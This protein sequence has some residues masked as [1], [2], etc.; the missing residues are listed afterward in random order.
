MIESDLPAAEARHHHVCKTNFLYN[1]N[2]SKNEP[3]DP[4][5]LALAYT[6]SENKTKMSNSAE[7]LHEYKGNGASTIMQK[8]LLFQEMKEYFKDAI[9]VM[10]SPGI[11]SIVAFTSETTKLFHLMKQDDD[12][13]DEVDV[14]LSKVAKK[15]QQD[16]G[17]C[18]RKRNKYRVNI[19]VDIAREPISETLLSLFEKVSGKF[20]HSL[21]GLLIG[22]KISGMVQ[23]SPTDLQISLG[24]P[25]R[26]NKSMITL[27]HNFGVCC[28]Y[29]EVT[30]FKHSTA[31]AVAEDIE[32]VKFSGKN[33]IHCCTD[34]FDCEISF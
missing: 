14:A 4:V 3:E 34:N 22:N 13:D 29:D 33:L 31:V 32:E 19:D 24:V 10:S 2:I 17:I 21:P 20:S 23:K 15:I 16:I 26:R 1:F 5:L 27:L 9:I 7:L 18:K 12:D 25:M 8:K 11:A 6:M 30:L 28:S